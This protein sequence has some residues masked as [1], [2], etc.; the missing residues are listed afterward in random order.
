MIKRCISLIKKIILV[1]T[2]L[3]FAGVYM[4]M[5][6]DELD[7]YDT[8]WE[9]EDISWEDI[10]ADDSGWEDEWDYE[11]ET[12]SGSILGSILGEIIDAA[13]SEDYES[14]YGPI[15]TSGDPDETWNI[16]WYLCGSDLESEYGAASD[17]L[18]EMMAVDLPKN[19]NVI[20]Q[21][22]GAEEW[23]NGRVKDDRI[24]RYVYSSK[25]MKLIDERRN[26]SMGDPDTLED[27]IEFCQENFPADKKAFIFWNHGGGSVT[28]A[29]FDENYNYDSLTLTDFREA[30]ENTCRLSKNN[31]PFDIIGFDACLMATVDTAS[32]FEGVGRYLVASEELEP[33]SG[34][35][36]EGFLEELADDPGMDG[37]RLGQVICDTYMEGCGWFSEDEATLSV[38]DLTEVGDLLT[39]Y[40]EMGRE[41]LSYAL[42]DPGFFASFGRKAEKSEN[43]GGN[44]REE[45][46][47]NMV[48]LKDLAENCRRL[49][50]E[51]TD[52]VIDAL[53]DCVLYQAKGEYRQ[54]AGGLSCYY[55]FNSD[56]DELYD[57]LD[58]GCSDSFKYLYRYGLTGKLPRGG[59]DFVRNLGFQK[60]ELPHVPS[61][62]DMSEKTFPLEL[63]EEGNVVLYLDENTTDILKSIRFR[64]AYLDEEN[65]RMVML[66]QDNDIDENW[67]EGI[68]KDNF[69]GVW[70][71]IDGYPVYME[72]SYEAEDYTAF[73]VPV[74]LNG[75]ECNLKV[76]YDY[77]D[78][79]FHIIG[80]R[81]GLDDNGMAD[82]N[83]IPVRIGDEITTV[84]KVSS[85]DENDD[86]IK[87]VT[88]D[89]FTVTEDTEFYEADMGDGVFVMMFEL[90]DSKNNSA[91]SE[92]AQFV[93]EGDYM[94]VEIIE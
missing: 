35:N 29:A 65:Q 7:S 50:P 20:I 18:M 6:E 94:E 93:V 30:F 87:G 13:L 11:D 54:N 4:F 60:E 80:A 79:E 53:D 14:D 42:E 23:E 86:E 72:V 76:V 3:I 84:L 78:E 75:K 39:A 43:Y 56:V 1:I 19:V 69:R 12:D 38:V 92:V 25:G 33:G 83:L 5:D 52:A 16:Y 37:A 45:G 88:G 22:G 71:S 17:D 8:S 91:Y 67:E 57:Y 9:D 58:Q 44:T 48:D 34:W 55:S 89:S 27:F 68:F 28:G 73:A 74:L 85:L 66:G 77:N 41:A 46:Y 32:A 36:Y 63:D 15:G 82:K 49:L 31:P 24:Q 47:A 62:E 10:F 51:T 90:I 26:A 40:D 70:G 2:A 81:E 21:T 61:L 64:M 59:M